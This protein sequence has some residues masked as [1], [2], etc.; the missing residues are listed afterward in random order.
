MQHRGCMQDTVAGA[1]QLA[2]LF[3]IEVGICAVVDAV[4]ACLDVC[5]KGELGK[6]VGQREKK[7]DLGEALSSQYQRPSDVSVQT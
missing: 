6:V 5:H 1:V 7:S 4:A 2:P 3:H